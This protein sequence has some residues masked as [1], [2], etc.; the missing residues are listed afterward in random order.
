MGH[1]ACLFIPRFFLFVHHAMSG[2][3]YLCPTSF[4]KKYDNFSLVCNK[5]GIYL[6]KVYIVRKVIS[7]LTC[8]T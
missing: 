3:E 4:G 6:R 1:S 8:L 5:M 7:A 2:T